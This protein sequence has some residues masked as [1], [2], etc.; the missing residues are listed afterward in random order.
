MSNALITTL[1]LVC[2]LALGLFIRRSNTVSEFLYNAFNTR[3]HSVVMSTVAA[4]VG[5]GSVVTVYAL[6]VHSPF[7]GVLI[8]LSIGLGLFTL[9]FAVPRMMMISRQYNAF[10]L[11]ETIRAGH[12]SSD[13]SWRLF[14]VP[15]Y[16]LVLLKLTTQLMALS[17]VV[18]TIFETNLYLSTII[19]IVVLMVYMLAAGYRAVTITDNLQFALIAGFA[20]LVFYFL[21]WP[22][23]SSS[24]LINT[25]YPDY[26]PWIIFAMLYLTTLSSMTHWRRIVT[27]KNPQ[28]TRWAFV[29]AAPI[30]A[31]IIL[32]FAVSGHVLGLDSPNSAVGLKL[33]LPS[34][35]GWLIHIGML[36]AILSSM[37]SGMISLLTENTRTSLCSIRLQVLGIGVVILIAAILFGDIIETMVSTYSALLALFPS[38]LM[39]FLGKASSARVMIISVFCGVL[40]SIATWNLHFTVVPAAALGSSALGYWISHYLVRAKMPE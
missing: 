20:V 29:I 19:S 12:A 2:M 33:L 27:T 11:L 26:F 36:M 3:F 8:A 17:L 5:A 28:S 39:V 13:R 23:D 10:G 16:V 34:Q 7:T 35:L 9:A 15:V 14:M 31:F 22:A 32:V 37:D 38:A 25:K 1:L 6:S 24:L 4:Q 18:N 21:Q 40:A 30:V